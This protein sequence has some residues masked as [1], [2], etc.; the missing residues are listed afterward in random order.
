MIKKNTKLNWSPEVGE[1]EIIKA[2]RKLTS[3]QA[4]RR[5]LLKRVKLN[6]QDIK[7]AKRELKAVTQQA[8]DIDPMT[9]PMRLFGEQQGS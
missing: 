5:A 4:K 8:I 9:P 2:A 3:L 7:A 6:A 1:R